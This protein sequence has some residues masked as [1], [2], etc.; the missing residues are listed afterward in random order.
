[1]GGCNCSPMVN[2]SELAKTLNSRLSTILIIYAI[3]FPIKYILI[4]TS[5]LFNAIIILILGFMTI[6][7]YYHLY[8]TLLCFFAMIGI[9]EE[10]IVI[11]LLIQNYFLGY[12][13]GFFIFI[14]QSVMIII[15][16]LIC[17][18]S[19][20]DY[21]ECRALSA[22]QPMPS[23]YYQNMNDEGENMNINQKGEAN[24]NTV[25]NK[26]YVPFS[27]KGVAVGSS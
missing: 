21:R 1:M 20:E 13:I 19:F 7:T 10:G 5:G 15:Y 17:K 26:G 14:V 8:A 12:K 2:P 11:L 6:R 3:I 27:G 18:T 24:Q 25:N 16:I 4:Y 23:S 22:E 9:V